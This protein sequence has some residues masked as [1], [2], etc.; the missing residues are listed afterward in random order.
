MPKGALLTEFEKGKIT[1]LKDQRKSMREIA[2]AIKR[3]KTVVCNY[4]QQKENYGQ[5]RFHGRKSKVTPRTKRKILRE[6]SNNSVSCNEIKG[7]LKLDLS[8]E[9]IRTILNNDE[10]MKYAKRKK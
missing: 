10:N 5:N 2:A 9:T 1:A 4:L 6:A 3:S 7:K 8:R